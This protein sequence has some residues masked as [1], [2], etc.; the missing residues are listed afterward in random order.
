MFD[1][2]IDRFDNVLRNLRGLGK[3]TDENIQQTA[4]EI[5]RILLD[6]DVNFRVSKEF[7]EKVKIR[8]EGTKVTRSVKPGEQFIKIISDELKELLGGDVSPLEIK[9]KKPVTILMAGLQGAGKT[10]TC[11]KLAYMLKGQGYSVMLVA[12]DIYRPAA[13]QQLKIVGEDVGVPVFSLKDKQPVTICTKA[14]AEAKA[15]NI[16][17]LILDTAGRLHVDESM[18]E[19]IQAIAK[20]LKPIENLFIADGMTGQD[21][22]NSAKAFSEYIDL[23]G[24]ILTKMDGDA[25][26]GAAVSVAS[27]TGKPIKFIGVSEKLD[28]LEVFDP[29]RV[30]DRILGK[31]DV[32]QLVE[33]AQGLMDEKDA[34]KIQERLAKNLFTLEDFQSSIAQMKKMGPMQDMLALLPGMNRKALKGLNL[35]DRQMLWTEAIISSMT[36]EERQNPQIINGSRRSRIAKGSGRSVQEINQLLKQYEQMKKMMKKFGNMKKG[37]LPF[38]KGKNLFL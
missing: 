37:S 9:G 26:G 27:V 21:A 20:K 17:V 15:E 4:R 32:I 1:Q 18:M 34:E 10:T 3:I 30:A 24:T 22:V 8:A 13:I 14:L 38:M 23:T 31:G 29:Q 16:D 5:R 12:A 36:V 25:R 2:I 6:A 33:K 11:G 35:D 28:G 7:I 19:E